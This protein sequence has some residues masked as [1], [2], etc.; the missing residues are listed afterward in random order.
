ME[1]AEFVDCIRT[2]HPVKNG[3]SNDAYE[4]MRLVFSIYEADELFKQQQVDKMR[5]R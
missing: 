2:G 3:T 1:L 5:N 4:T